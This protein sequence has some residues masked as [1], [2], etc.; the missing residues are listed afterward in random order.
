MLKITKMKGLIIRSPWIDL[1]LSGKKTWEIRGQ[2][3]T[4]LETIALIKSGTK[5]IVGVAKLRKVYGPLSLKDYILHKDKHLALDEELEEGLP[6]KTTYAWE[7]E[8]VIQLIEPV[9]YNHPMGSIIWVNLND[10]SEE[11]LLTINKTYKIPKT[12]L[13]ESFIQSLQKDLELLSDKVSFDTIEESNCDQF[14]LESK[15]FKYQDKESISNIYKKIRERLILTDKDFIEKMENKKDILDYFASG[16]EIDVEKIK[17]EI[18]ICETKSEKDIFKYCRYLQ[19]VPNSGGIGRRIFAIVY[20]V[21]QEREYIMG[22]IGL[23][24]CGYSLKCRDD[25]FE[26]NNKSIDSFIKLKQIKDDG[27]KSI[28]QLSV[29][30]AVPP[31]NYLYSGKLISLLAL[32]NPIQ[33]H[34]QEKFKDKENPKNKP[35]LLA[36]VTTSATGVHNAVFNRI[37]LKK[38][39]NDENWSRKELFEKIGISSE[40]STL[41]LSSDTKKIAKELL[42]NA[43]VYSKKKNGK[44]TTFNSD[45][46]ITKAI[47]ICGL[48][49][50]ILE[51]NEKAVY[52]GALHSK[53]IEYLKG[54]TVIPTL[55]LSVETAFNYWKQHFLGKKILSVGNGNLETFKKFDKNMLRISKQ[56]K[57][58]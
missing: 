16:S 57:L 11:N 18:R 17:P 8:D 44:K 22:A 23:A 4:N 30:L 43:K 7:L 31:Y 13:R 38:I 42:L 58:F 40:Y 19:E 35:K 37:Q 3:T 32:S 56:L 5:T 15:H 29:S 20:D 14:K 50:E 21:G 48:N 54:N 2:K 27:L 51:L 39:F 26:W 47:Q 52:L 24:S 34:F 6:Y 10:I 46:D 41:I 36:L 9:P 55:E 33:N 45:S 49:K 25:Y 28:M 12:S 1:I 53:N